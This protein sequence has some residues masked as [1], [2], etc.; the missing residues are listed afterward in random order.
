MPRYIRPDTL[1]SNR[2]HTATH[3]SI[4]GLHAHVKKAN[5]YIAEILDLA[6]KY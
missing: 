5:V 6:V 4:L 1:P 3:R 2:P